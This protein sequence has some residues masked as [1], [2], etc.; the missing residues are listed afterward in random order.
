MTLIQK[1]ILTERYEIDRRAL[2]ILQALQDY[3]LS[4]ID[5]LKKMTKISVNTINSKLNIIKE[6]KLFYEI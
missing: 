4:S 1:Q 3:P 6:Q 5:D 2:T